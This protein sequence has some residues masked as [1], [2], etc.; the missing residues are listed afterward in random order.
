MKNEFLLFSTQ[1]FLYF[2][3]SLHPYTRWVDKM[4]NDYHLHFSEVEILPKELY[5]LLLF[6]LLL[7]IY[8]Y[9]LYL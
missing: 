8:D 2:L 7:R 1:Q 3:R 4:L 6:L 9:V 5:V